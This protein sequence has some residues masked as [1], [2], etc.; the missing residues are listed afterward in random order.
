MKIYLVDALTDTPDK[1]LIHKIVVAEND[2][3]A[4]KL[5]D[6][7]GVALNIGEWRIRKKF[8]LPTGP[9][10]VDQYVS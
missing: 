9:I 7:L 2:D 3:E 10:L 4:I 1:V 5:A 6:S 8:S